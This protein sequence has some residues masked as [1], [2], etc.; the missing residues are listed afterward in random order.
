MAKGCKL[1]FVQLRALP[2]TEKKEYALY[3]EEIQTLSEKPRELL[4]AEQNAEFL[5]LRARGE[6]YATIAKKY[7][8]TTSTVK[9]RIDGILNEVIA[10][11]REQA[12]KLELIR[13]DQ[14]LIRLEE[15]M[16]DSPQ[17]VTQYLQVCDRRARL[18][19]LDAPREVR[20]AESTLPELPSNKLE[21]ELVS[22]EL[23]RLD[24]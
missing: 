7:G 12:I 16:E 11:P 1:P 20:L 13:F 8:L 9:E 3:T 18:L 17:Y 5:R 21:L 6:S 2:W 22:Q 15:W 14:L 10:E 19:G 4:K 23:L 24:A